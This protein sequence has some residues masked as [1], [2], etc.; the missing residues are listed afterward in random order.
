[1]TAEPKDEPLTPDDVMG[2]D[3]SNGDEGGRSGPPRDASAEA[4]SD[5]SESSAAQPDEVAR[6]QQENA[7][8]VDQVQRARAELANVRRRTADQ[9][10]EMQHRVAVDL[11]RRVLPVLDD[12]NKALEAHQQGSGEEQLAQGLRMVVDK[13]HSVLDT[14]EVERVPGVGE[15]FDPTWHEALLQC[16]TSDHA[17]G[18]I[19][20]EF[21]T[22][23]RLGRELIRA[24][25]VS[26]AKDP[27]SA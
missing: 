7:F 25:R 21:E 5:A 16:E 26:V 12:L 19:V 4:S 1:M 10:V 3:E 22:G 6:L 13:F 17:P 20:Q 24:S 2:P 8:L 27:E 14:L 15:P 18:T 23:Y 11:V 9:R